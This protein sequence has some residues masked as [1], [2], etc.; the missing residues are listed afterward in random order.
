MSEPFRRRPGT[1]S[2]SKFIR[3]KAE[4]LPP[5]R[6]PPKT[7]GVLARTYSPAGLRAIER[8]RRLRKK[9]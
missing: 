3:S 5:F 6:G 2:R 1:Y 8:L 7:P 4:V 9:P